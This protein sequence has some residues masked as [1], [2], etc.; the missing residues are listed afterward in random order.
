MT[1]AIRMFKEISTA[2]FNSL[3]NKLH[4]LSRDRKAYRASFKQA[5]SLFFYY[6]VIGGWNPD[7][8]KMAFGIIASEII[9]LLFARQL[10]IF[11]GVVAFPFFIVVAGNPSARS[12]TYSR[13]LWLRILR[14]NSD[15]VSQAI[16]DLAEAHL[17]YFGN[18]L[19]KSYSFGNYVKLA[20][21]VSSL[22]VLLD[23]SVIIS[24]IML[25][26]YANGVRDSEVPLICEIEDIRAADAV[27]KTQPSE[28]RA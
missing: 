7:F 3:K 1:Y 21:F 4:L 23:I 2:D 19:N 22:L 25:V 14:N 11:D 5:R 10:L 15:N 8:V 6:G 28:K 12:A 13:Y 26:P 20:R 18:R 27:E 9:C 17:H 16:V 24:A